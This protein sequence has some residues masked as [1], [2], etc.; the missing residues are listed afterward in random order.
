MTAK[1]AYHHGKL[2]PA[3]IAAALR[4]LAH[5][6]PEGFSLRGVARRAGVSAPAV[7]RHFEDKDA[8]LVAVAAECA[9]R[10]GAAMVDAV[11][12]APAD[13]LERFRAVGIALVRFAVAQPEHFRALSVPGLAE[14][15]P[16]AQ[17]A[18]ERAWHEAERAGLAEAQ[19]QGLIADLPLTAI[20]LTA[21]AAMMGLAHA[22][23][24]GRLGEVDDARA[25][26]LAIAVTGVLGHGFVP[27]PAALTDPRRPRARKR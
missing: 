26:E 6:G 24:E 2:K 27:R 20:M 1:P 25:T 8:L 22:I 16:P 23:I 7:Y 21:N 18:R 9:E 4:E 5:E 11:A 19:R 13:P 17:R 12:K 15:T 14:K 10:L 3:L